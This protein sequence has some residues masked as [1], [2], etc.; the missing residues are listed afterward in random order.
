MSRALVLGFC[1]ALPLQTLSSLSGDKCWTGTDYVDLYFRQFN[2]H[3]PLPHLRSPE[4]KALFEHLIDPCNLSQ[5]L[6]RPVSVDEKLRQLRIILASLGGF[7]AAYE[8]AVMVGEPLE[9][10]LA[11]VQAYSLQVADAEWSLHDPH[12]QNQGK[13]SWSTMVAGVLD[14]IGNTERYTPSQAMLMADAVIQYYPAIAKALAESDRQR[15]RSKVEKLV[16][17]GGNAE[18]VRAIEQMKQAVATSP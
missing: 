16:P 11:S 13:A 9:Q 2:G 10:E 7:R 17:K 18:L 6:A 8:V 5:F 15:L 14:S 1:L 4:Q 12:M 3:V